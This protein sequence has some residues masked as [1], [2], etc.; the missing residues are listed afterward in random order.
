MI[1]RRNTRR[2]AAAATPPADASLNAA[3]RAAEAISAPAASLNLARRVAETTSA[4]AASLNAARRAAELTRLAEGEAV[5]V[6]VV[7]GGITGAGVALDAASRGLSVA[8]L[9]RRDLAHGTSRWSSKLVH[10]G[11]RYLAHGDVGL[12]W[13]SALERGRLMRRIA[14]HLV[15]PL[16]FVT[17]E[18]GRRVLVGLRAGDALRSAA[19][20]PRSL[21]PA[22]RRISGLEAQRLAPALRP[23]RDA[24]LHWDGQL[25][26]DARLVVAVARTAAAHGARILTR[27]EVVRVRPDGVDAVDALTGAAFAVR[28]RHVIVAAGVWTGGLAPSV[29]LRPSRGSHLLVP[30][31]RLGHPRAGVNCPVPGERGRWISA[32]PRADGLVAI[33]LTDVPADGPPVD[34]PWPSAAEEADLLEQASAVLAVPLGPADVVGRYAGLRPLLA[35]A[36]G[37]TA[38]LS[39]RHSVVRDEETGALVLVG[40]KLTTYR[41]MAQDAVDRLTQRPCQTHRLALVGAG[42]AAGASPALVRRYGGEAA[43]VAAMGSV[44]PLAPDVPVCEAELRWAVEHE[45]AL[46]AE[47][48]ADRRTR[49]GL[50]PAWRAAVFEAAHR[51][52]GVSTVGQQ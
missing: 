43:A 42:P 39:R 51:L 26:D 24:A 48:L 33:G 12:A 50:V 27:A 38:D 37:R 34:E 31:E 35:G 23:A 36:A 28:A 11:L 21:L 16:P 49:A 14:P 9:E 44:A 52:V 32:V 20:T 19:R 17:P 4:P 15:R 22:P 25:E 13:E 45:L 7:G 46:T 1:P 41:R 29:A 2:R 10:G 5:D 3:R 8:L 30:A 47:D 6:V 18:P 40:G